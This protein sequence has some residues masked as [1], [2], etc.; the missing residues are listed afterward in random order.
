MFF[1][2]VRIAT[3]NLSRR[4]LRTSL[5]MLGMIFGVAAVL[6]MMSIGAGA[7]KETLNRIQRMGLRNIVIQAKPFDN[8][9]LTII[10]Q[11]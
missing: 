4:K 1:E 3:D 6:A 2:L 5:T 8:N 7:E 9:E 10:R 11:D